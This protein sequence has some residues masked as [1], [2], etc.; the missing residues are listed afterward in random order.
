MAGAKSSAAMKAGIKPK[1]PKRLMFELLATQHGRYAQE[2]SW[3]AARSLA[4]LLAGLDEPSS[5]RADI[6][7]TSPVL[8]EMLLARAIAERK[9]EAE[10]KDQAGERSAADVLGEELLCLIVQCGLSAFTSQGRKGYSLQPRRRS[11]G[12]MHW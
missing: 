1:V 5:T 4:C 8:R 2:L 11:G 10:T 12:R 6:A 3:L 7:D 9:L